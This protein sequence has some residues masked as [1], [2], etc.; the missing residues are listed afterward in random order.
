VGE[1][2]SAKLDASRLFV[3]SDDGAAE[4]PFAAQ[5]A[6]NSGQLDATETA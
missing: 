1:L 4:G 6:G 5:S 3:A 2:W